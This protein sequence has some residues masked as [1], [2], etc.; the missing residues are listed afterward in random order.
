MLLA[1]VE[2]LLHERRQLDVEAARMEAEIGYLALVLSLCL[3]L[4][5][6]CT[7]VRLELV[8]LLLHFS[9]LIDLILYL[10]HIIKL[11][12]SCK[13]L[14]NDAAP[15]DA[16]EAVS[17]A[18]EQLHGGLLQIVLVDVLAVD[19]HDM[20]VGL[21]LAKLAHQDMECVL[22]VDVHPG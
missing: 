19:R 7:M 15:F 8:Q 5:L 2:R 12:M 17:A 4:H 11:L 21:H 14:E 16:V 18:E 20:L 13:H 6:L 10:E 22:G 9:N 1:H 3:R